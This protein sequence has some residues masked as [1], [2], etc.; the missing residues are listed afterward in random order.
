M[1]LR[2]P[3]TSAARIE[4]QGG[5]G[6]AKL[7]PCFTRVKAGSDFISPSGTWET[8]GFSLAAHQIVVNFQGGVGELKV[9]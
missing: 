4:V 6:G 5:L 8:T 9:S 2:L 3:E 1:N 7:A